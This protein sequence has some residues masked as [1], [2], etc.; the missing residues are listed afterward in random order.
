MALE[1]KPYSC[2]EVEAYFKERDNWRTHVSLTLGALKKS[3][4]ALFA[5]SELRE[6]SEE[7]VAVAV[8]KLIAS[9]RNGE[10]HDIYAYLGQTIRRDVIHCCKARQRRE[11]FDEQHERDEQPT[12]PPFDLELAIACVKKQMKDPRDHELVEMYADSKPNR[13][14][15]ALDG[16][17]ERQISRLRSEIAK[18]FSGCIKRLLQSEKP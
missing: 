6:Q 14:M 7:L 4:G 12:S 2:A 10:V 13:D 3:C 11:T 9:C 17:G 18:K 15:R 1:R 16:R 5:Q 8:S